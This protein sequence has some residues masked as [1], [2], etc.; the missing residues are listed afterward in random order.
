MAKS[1]YFRRSVNILGSLLVLGGLATLV[2]VM[3]SYWRATHPSATP[4]RW[5]KSES[6]IGINIAQK[7][8]GHQRI[9]I[10]KH[11][12]AISGSEPASRI[13]I[14]KIGLDAAVVETP[15]TGGVWQ[16]ADWAVGHLTSTPNPGSAGNS[17]LS[18]HDDIKG[19]IFKRLG[20]LVPGDQVR[21]YTR[22]A[23]FTYIVTGQQ[24]VDPSDVAVLNPTK[25]A[26]ITLITCTPYWVDTQRLVVQGLLKSSVAV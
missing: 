26:T 19:E 11:L 4:P 24:A 2:F 8:R 3:A 13:V 7:L 21:V 6:R 1:V 9:A 14:P 10:P 18:A 16:V 12:V 15:P 25:A 17:A 5:T 20:E 22:H 23:L